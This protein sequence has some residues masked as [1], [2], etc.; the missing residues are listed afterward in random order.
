MASIDPPYEKKDGTLTYRVRWRKGGR[1]DGKREGESFDDVG[2]AEDVRDAV[3]RAGDEWPWGYVPG[4]GWD[5][6][7][8]AA[9]L[10]AAAQPPRPEAVKFAKFAEDW[11]KGR[12]K[13]QEN[14]RADY[15]VDIRVH[16]NPAFGD[17]DIG[18]EEAISEDTVNKWVIGLLEGA[19]GRKPLK[20]GTVRKMHTILFSIL[21]AAV[22]RKLR[23]TNPCEDT[24]LPETNTGAEQDEMVFL[25]REEFHVLT[26]F[27][28]PD[29]RD[30]AIIAV[31]TGLR[32]GELTALQVRDV[33]NLLSPK[34]YLRIRRAWKRQP[35][36]TWKLGPPKSKRSRRNVSVNK[37]IAYILAGLIANKGQTDFL[38]LTPRGAVWR[39][40]YFYDAR[41]RP[42]V[43]K[44]I[45]CEKH[46]AEDN[47]KRVHSGGVRNRHLVPCGCPGQLEQVP[48]I[49]DLRHTHA[50]WL[51]ADGAGLT[52]VQR[53]L[54]HQNVQTTERYSHL[55]PEVDDALVAA[56]EA[57]WNRTLPKAS[58]TKTEKALAA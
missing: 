38:F 41:W 5:H 40:N 49:H 26:E 51:I 43:Y 28:A 42:S 17:A 36:N 9:L 10:D 6:Q 18:D 53:R 20:P 8:Y 47:I 24:E 23:N 4:I 45:R 14:T 13:A 57:G 48:R 56:L 46:R 22:R 1:R 44:A 54:G 58:P 50:S 33:R 27:L 39:H 31:N 30:M 29:I 12:T 15:L 55:L 16:M 32:F 35:D 2:A 21:K 37:A 11:A 3:T 7:A 19:N 52:A 34:P 25:T